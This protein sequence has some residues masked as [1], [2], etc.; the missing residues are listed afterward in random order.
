MP[1]HLCWHCFNT[2]VDINAFIDSGI[3]FQRTTV[4]QLLPTH[5]AIIEETSCS[6]IL[7]V[8]APDENVHEEVLQGE[9]VEEREIVLE[10]TGDQVG[11][12]SILAVVKKEARSEASYSNSRNYID[13]NS[14]GKT[15]QESDSSL[16]NLS[17]VNQTSGKAEAAP[18]K[19]N[20]QGKSQKVQGNID[21]DHAEKGDQHQGEKQVSEGTKKPVTSNER[22]KCSY[23]SKTFRRQSQLKSHLASHSDA[24]PHQCQ[25][26]GVAFKHRRNLVEH[27]HTHS[28]QP[29]FICAVCGLTFKQ[30][31]K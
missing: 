4:N 31:S 30:K 1:H 25:V 10:A 28:Q 16:Q 17:Q 21:C 9:L 7:P 27:S 12:A 5:S 15:N 23:C 14:E 29:S 22:E 13:K 8:S 2:S 18:V 11:S 24:R 3:N 26:C 6:S 20:F 19:E